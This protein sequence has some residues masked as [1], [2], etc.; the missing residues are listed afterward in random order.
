MRA[1]PKSWALKKYAILEA[2]YLNKL[3]LE[4]LL[5]SLLTHEM[6]LN[7]DEEQ[8]PKGDRMRGLAPKSKVV[9]ESKDEEDEDNDEEMSIYPRRFKHFM[10]K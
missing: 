7:E 2:K 5:S 10:R 9:E 4:E 3:P 1:L 8:T 6:R